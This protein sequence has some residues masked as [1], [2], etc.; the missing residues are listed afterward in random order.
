[1]LE[2][3][4]YW[5]VFLYPLKVRIVL[6]ALEVD[7]VPSDVCCA[8]CCGDT[9]TIVRSGMWTEFG[10]FMVCVIPLSSSIL[11]FNVPLPLIFKPAEIHLHY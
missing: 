1:M 5:M 6:F 7:I 10:T 4:E 3:A 2:F 8:Q 9:S 11:N